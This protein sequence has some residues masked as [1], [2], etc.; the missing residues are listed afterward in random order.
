MKE[1]SKGNSSVAALLRGKWLKGSAISGDL[2]SF[3]E[4]ADVDQLL[5]PS[6]ELSKGE[7]KDVNGTPAITLEE[8]SADGDKLYVA[9]VGPP[10]PLR[11][12]GEGGGSR[13]TLDFSEFGA[14]VDIKAPLST[15]VVDIDQ[16]PS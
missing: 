12:E 1:L 11:I 10:Y 8:K 6:G 14:E 16:L 4:I 15:E 7:T 9:T 3:G 2:S 13:G 5:K